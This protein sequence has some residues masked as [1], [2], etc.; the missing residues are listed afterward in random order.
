MNY[1]IVP[2]NTDNSKWNNTILDT[3]SNKKKKIDLHFLK[4]IPVLAK[5]EKNC[6]KVSVFASV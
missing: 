5:Q 1:W 6:V 4:E 2:H 3:D